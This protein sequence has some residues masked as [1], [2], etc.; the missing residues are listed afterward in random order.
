MRKV[1]IIVLLLTIFDVTARGI[2]NNYKVERVRVDKS[3][4][5]YIMFNKPLVGSP[6]D[7]IDG[8]DSHLA[9]DLN[10]PGGKGIMSMALSAQA[11]GKNIKASGSGDCDIYNVV[12]TWSWG[13]IVN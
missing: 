8:H 1:L 2:A 12:E 7:C 9:F 10:T 6:A 11:T 3:G 5:G 13:Y 4:F